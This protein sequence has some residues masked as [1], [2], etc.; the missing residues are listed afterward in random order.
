[1]PT[2]LHILIDKVKAWSFYPPD[3]RP[4]YGDSNETIFFPAGPGM[5]H[6][7]EGKLSDK[8]IM[9][10]CNRYTPQLNFLRLHGVRQDWERTTIAWSEVLNTLTQAGIDPL[11]CFFTN[12]HLGVRQTAESRRRNQDAGSWML[13]AGYSIPSSYFRDHCRDILRF[14][15]EL[16]HPR[17]ILVLGLRAASFISRLHPM[18]LAWQNIQT[19]HAVDK[20][21]Q[22]IIRDVPLLPGQLTTIVL[23][24]HPVRRKTHISTR[25]DGRAIGYDAEN[26][27]L[28]TVVASCKL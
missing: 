18:L 9:V 19:Y 3:I 2:E 26:R 11:D 14:T 21:Y 28:R 13:D 15:V 20:R 6:K 17:L 25:K 27:L 24:L 10:I 1:M 5:Y 23:L 4:L 8:P 22:S 16:Q 7:E 12:C